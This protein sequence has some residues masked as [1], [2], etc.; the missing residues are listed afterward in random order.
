MKYC[1]LPASRA[2]L[3]SASYSMTGSVP[4]KTRSMA[5]ARS[6]SARLSSLKRIQSFLGF[7]GSADFGSC[8]VST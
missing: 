6:N 3:V 7:S 2:S 4:W 5:M 8:A 1:G